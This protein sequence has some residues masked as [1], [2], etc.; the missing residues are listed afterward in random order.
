MIVRVI[1]T[2]A[3]SAPVNVTATDEGIHTLFAKIYHPLRHHM[4]SVDV[5]NVVFSLKAYGPEL[6]MNST[7]ATLF[8]PTA[9]KVDLYIGYRPRRSGRT[10]RINYG[11]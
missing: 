4:K 3:F 10:A 1:W 2:N 9:E 5:S 8:G 11:E 6:D 7:F